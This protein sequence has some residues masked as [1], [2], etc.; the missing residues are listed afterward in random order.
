MAT[1]QGDGPTEPAPDADDAAASFLFSEQ[2]LVASL[3]GDKIKADEEDDAMNPFEQTLKDCIDNMGNVS[4]Q[5][6]IAQRCYREC[7]DDP[8][9]KACKTFS[10]KSRFRL[11]WAQ[12]KYSQ[13]MKTKTRSK[14]YTDT[15]F[16]NAMYE[17]FSI[18]VEKEGG[19]QQGRKAAAHY[20]AACIDKFKAGQRHWVK[21]NKMTKRVEYL[22]TK[23]GKNSTMADQW[24]L[25]TTEKETW[26]RGSHSVSASSSTDI[27]GAERIGDK[28]AEKT[29]ESTEDKQKKRK[30]ESELATSSAVKTKGRYL[31]LTSQ[32]SSMKASIQHSDDW[33]WANN[34][35]MQ[36]N[37]DKTLREVQASL[38][39]FM[40]DFVTM[41]L[42]DCKRKYASAEF[43]AEASKV[44]STFEKKLDNLEKELKRLL[45][46][47]R[48]YQQEA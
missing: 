3:S 17:P 14:T 9:F 20:C 25:T 10:D 32:A 38:T 43:T 8:G 24:S 28:P 1:T 21:Y 11:Q 18:I 33:G 15:T 48:A 34:E 30:S 26:E 22:Y 23:S 19:G 44:S 27:A 29:L 5:S 6:A 46:M 2:D 13:L 40:R 36:K 39:P 42:K 35:H 12:A 7:K 16:E 45:G 41:E 4:S 31:L 37:L 47:H